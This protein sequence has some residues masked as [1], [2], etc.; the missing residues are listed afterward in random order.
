MASSLTFVVHSA[1]APQGSKRFVGNGVMVESSKRVKPFRQDVRY[2]ALD[3]VPADWNR[4]GPMALT[5]DFHFVR[6]KSHLTSKG[7]LTKSAPLFPTARTVGDIEKLVRAVN[8][9]LSGIAFDDDSQV[10]ELH[11]RKLYS[12]TALTI[13]TLEHL[14]PT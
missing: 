11:T 4:S 10:V 9:A 7:N 3:A 5:V 2:T 12:D 14:D 13:I 1:A 6:P 8:D